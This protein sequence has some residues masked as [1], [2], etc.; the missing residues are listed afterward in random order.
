MKR[1]QTVGKLTAERLG[2]GRVLQNERG[3]QVPATVQAGRQP[4]MTFEQGAALS[5]QR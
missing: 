1:S 3:L 2:L 4:E 5:K